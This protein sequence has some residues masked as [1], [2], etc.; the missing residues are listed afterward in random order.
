MAGSDLCHGVLK[1]LQDYLRNRFLMMVRLAKP[2]AIGERS[3]NPIGCLSK[4]L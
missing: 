2:Q 3:Y 1:T 4:H